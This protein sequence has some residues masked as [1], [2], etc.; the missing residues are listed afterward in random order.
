MKYERS[1]RWIRTHALVEEALS[2]DLSHDRD[3]VFS[4]LREG[5]SYIAVDALSP[6]SGFR[7]WAE[8]P[9]GELAMGAEAPG[10]R[11]SLRAIL[12]APARLR[13][14]RDGGEVAVSDAPALAYDVAE[15]GV[16]RVEA[17]LERHGRMR[18]WILSNP[19]YLRG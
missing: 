12:P 5:R 10:G 6:A 8:G 3:Q 2:G 9:E 19:L 4:A 13:L 11:Y 16:Y 7:F 18:T 1:F 14:L 17:Y 15:P